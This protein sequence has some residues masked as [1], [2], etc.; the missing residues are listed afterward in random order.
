LI[1]D[2]ELVVFKTS[3]SGS[4][5]AE[6]R[7]FRHLCISSRLRDF[8]VKI[9]PY[10]AGAANGITAPPQEFFYREGAKTRTNA[11]MRFCGI[12]VAGAAP[13]GSIGLR[14]WQK[15]SFP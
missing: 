7:R 13:A 2:I 12:W 14:L 11:K 9:R 15:L 6:C 5:A 4:V 10:P 1:E 8:A 3:S